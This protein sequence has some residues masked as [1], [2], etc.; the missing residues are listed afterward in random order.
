M[1]SSFIN[2]RYSILFKFI[3]AINEHVET[4][5]YAIVKIRTK[6]FKKEVVKKC[7]FKCDKKDN[8]K[9]NHAT[10]KRFDF[11]RLINCQFATT[12]LLIENE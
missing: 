5:K 9:N 8:S 7:V 6:T 12:A 11:S 3:D 1:K 10:N 2:R 4:E